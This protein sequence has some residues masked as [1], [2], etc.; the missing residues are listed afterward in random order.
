MKLQEG[1][2]FIGICSQV[3]VCPR[4]WRGARVGGRYVSSGDHQVSLAGMGR[5][6]SHGKGLV[7][8]GVGILSPMVYPPWY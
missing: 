3:S 5:Y 1:N 7:C 8:R 2:V 4:W 6:T